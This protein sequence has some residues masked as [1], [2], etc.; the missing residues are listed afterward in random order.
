MGIGH[1]G[2]MEYLMKHDLLNPHDPSWSFQKI[3]FN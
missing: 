2:L 1:V 3:Y